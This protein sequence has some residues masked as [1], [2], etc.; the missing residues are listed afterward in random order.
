MAVQSGG[1]EWPAQDYV[2]EGQEAPARPNAQVKGLK[3]WSESWVRVQSWERY[4]SGLKSELVENQWQE[5]RVV[6]ENTLGHL[7]AKLTGGHLRMG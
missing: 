3:V 5:Y 7:K 6:T 1:P 4:G 2:Q